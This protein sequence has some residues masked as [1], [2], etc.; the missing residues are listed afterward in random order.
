LDRRTSGFEP[1]TREYCSSRKAQLDAGVVPG[2]EGSSGAA[3][4]VSAK[5]RSTLV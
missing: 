2:M 1:R 5:L 3:D 4:E